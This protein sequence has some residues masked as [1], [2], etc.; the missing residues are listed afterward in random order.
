M[1]LQIIE[2]V[3]RLVCGTIGKFVP[4][5]SKDDM[6]GD[7]LLG[8]RR[9]T[10]NIRWKEYWM[11]KKHRR[12]KNNS[13]TIL[14]FQQNVRR[15]RKQRPTIITDTTEMN[16]KPFAFPNVVPDKKGLGTNLKPTESE[17]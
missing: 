6:L 3:Q 5:P 11:L 17:L 14:S 15:K 12:R 7:L 8:T 4:Q 2:T 13:K 9:F 1:N 16:L 10:N